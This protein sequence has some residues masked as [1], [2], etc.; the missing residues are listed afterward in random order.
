MPSFGPG[1]EP[2]FVADHQSEPLPTAT[3]IAYYEQMRQLGVDAQLTA[4]PVPLQDG[5]HSAQRNAQSVRPVRRTTRAV[6]FGVERGVD[7]LFGS[8]A[9]LTL[10]AEWHYDGRRQ[11]RATSVWQNDLFIAGFL[12][13]NDVP[14]TELADRPPGRPPSMTIGL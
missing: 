8:R 3:L 9:D 14:G 12:A 5:G 4:G 6:V 1:R 11:R 2:L 10:L 7:A 13:F